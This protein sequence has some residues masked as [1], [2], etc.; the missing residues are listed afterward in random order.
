MDSKRTRLVISFDIDGVLND[1]PHCWLQYLNLRT[2]STFNSKSAA[3][4]ILGNEAYSQIKSD[5]R[6]SDYKKNIPINESMKTLLNT[7]A[8]EGHR[9][10]VSTSRPIYSPR[11]KLLENL[12][13]SWLKNNNV[14]FSKLTFKDEAGKFIVENGIQVHIDDEIKY[15][16]IASERGAKAIIFNKF[17][18]EN[19]NRAHITETDQE[20][21]IKKQIP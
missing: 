18:R 15:A 21:M 4:A 12:T 6:H 16:D 8:E 13:A 5:Y 19:S 1:Y 14:N 2:K 17:S 10:I 11:Y 9:I 3:I 7:L 20:S